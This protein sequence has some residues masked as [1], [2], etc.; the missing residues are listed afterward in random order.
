MANPWV[1]TAVLIAGSVIVA[2]DTTIVNTALHTIRAELHT[3]NGVQWVVTAYL[4]AVCAVLPSS[5]WLANRFGRKTVFLSTLGIFVGAS[6]GCGL[7]PDL[8]WLIAF[9]ALQGLGGGILGAVG[10]AM[11]IGLFPADRLGRAMGVASMAGFLGPALGPSIGGLVVEKVSWHWLFFINVPVGVIALVAGLRLLP[12]TGPRVQAPFD[13]TGLLLGSGGLTLTVVAL[14]QGNDWGWRSPS[15]I[16]SSTA[17]LA[18][19]AGFVAYELQTPHPIIQIR[20]FSQ[21]QFRL[22]MGALL[23]ITMAQFGRLIFIP[24]QL[25]SLRGYT[26]LYVGVLLIPP[27]IVSMGVT[28]LGGRL[29]DQVGVRRPIMIGC[30]LAFLAMVGMARLALDTPIPVILGLLI[31]QSIGMGLVSAPAVVAGMRD[32]P[33]ELVPHGTALRS[34]NGQ[35]AGAVAIALLGAVVSIR[36][37]SGPSPA[38]AQ[39]A[40]NAGFVIAAIGAALAFV[41]AARLPKGPAASTPEPTRP[42]PVTASV[43]VATMAD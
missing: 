32:L 13:V 26:P 38:H 6:A 7:S 43:P 22:A 2:I 14:S 40:Y 9:R 25:E 41:L 11:I 4:L 42:V 21:R 15:I 37:G 10:M 23:F 12:D 1:P 35:I 28:L 16:T 24:L 36:M 8:G 18:G 20:L 31:L 3:G 19:L 5:G 27:A 33:P 39:A 17:G 34:L 29:A 30:T